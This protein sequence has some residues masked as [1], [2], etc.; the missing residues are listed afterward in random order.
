MP[1]RVFALFLLLTFLL[2]G[3][4]APSYEETVTAPTDADG[5]LAVHFL[6]VGQADCILIQQ[7]DHA[8]L[9]DAGNNGDGEL[10]AN[11]LQSA[12]VSRLDY[13]VGTHPHEDHIGAL[14]TVLKNFP[15]Q[16]LLMPRVQTNTKT[17]EDVLDAAIEKG[18]SITAP[19]AGD[20]F[21]LGSA[22]LTAVNNYTGDDLND[23]SI[24]LRLTYGSVSFLFTGD[25][26]VPA[27]QAALAT[28]LPLRSDVLKVGHHGSSTS[29]SETFLAAV[30]PTY[31]VITCGVDNDYGHPHEET[32]A[33]LAGCEIFR[34]DRQ[35]TIVAH[36]DGSKITWSTVSNAET[37]IFEDF[38]YILNTGSGKFHLPTCGGVETMSPK[39]KSFTNETRQQ[40]LARGY[41][42]CGSCNP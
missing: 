38:I 40:L 34:T 23:H 3:C 31:A 7:G 10:I 2:C 32:L 21:P 28:G 25:A 27:E 11:Y 4:L 1:K 17:F 29:T 30:S 41:T 39:N 37:P 15:V 16:N 5:G 8:M 33:A 9:I 35:G 14:D 20:T 13:A 12:G 24:M 19:K 6:D 22:V 18:L 36:S 26:E 42:P